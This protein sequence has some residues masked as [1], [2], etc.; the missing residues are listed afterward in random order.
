[1]CTDD[2]SQLQLRIA[3]LVPSNLRSV[4]TMTTMVW[5]CR[6]CQGLQRRWKWGPH[7][8]LLKTTEW[9]VQVSASCAVMA[10]RCWRCMEQLSFHWYL[11]W[12]SKYL[13]HK[14]R[15]PASICHG[16]SYPLSYECSVYWLPCK[17]VTSLCLLACICTSAPPLAVSMQVH[18][19]MSSYCRQKTVQVDEYM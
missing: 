7:C 13:R 17:S 2:V 15:C 16:T 4:L 8:H 12:H 3:P 5:D 19:S 6:R 18:V 10:P 9:A 14:S 11:R 1:M